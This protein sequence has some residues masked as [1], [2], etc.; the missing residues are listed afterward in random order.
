[1]AKPQ[2]PEIARSGRGATDPASVKSELTVP[3]SRRRRAADTDRAPVPEHNRPGHHPGEDQDKPAGEV[4]VAKLHEHADAAGPRSGADPDPTVAGEA[5]R[6][7][8]NVVRKVR[9]AL[10]GD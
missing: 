1:M 2:Q 6:T 10:P 4:F 5:F 9:E 7:A 3:R 8:A